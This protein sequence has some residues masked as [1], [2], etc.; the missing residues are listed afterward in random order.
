MNFQD[1]Y[2]LWE[3]RCQVAFIY[4]P[5]DFRVFQLL[6]Y[7]DKSKILLEF[8]K[9]TN[10]IAISVLIVVSYDEFHVISINVSFSCQISKTFKHGILLNSMSVIP[11]RKE[12][13]WIVHLYFITLHDQVYSWQERTS[14][15]FILCLWLTWWGLK[16]FSTNQF[17]TL[18]HLDL[19]SLPMCMRSGPGSEQ[20]VHSDLH[21][22]SSGPSLHGTKSSC[23]GGSRM[24][25]T[26]LAHSN[27]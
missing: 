3:N 16:E 27:S 13:K 25:W 9:L 23:P 8:M 18:R 1:C 21:T 6:C 22:T 12:T 2:Q 24:F 10:Q 26:P 5:W 19:V 14:V 4:E 17:L 20:H 7:T 15:W 11:I